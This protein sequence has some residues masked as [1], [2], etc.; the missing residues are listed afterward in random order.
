MQWRQRRRGEE[1]SERRWRRRRGASSS[2]DHRSEGRRLGGVLGLGAAA[3]GGSGAE[4]ER[5]RTGRVGRGSACRRREAPPPKSG[6]GGKHG[7]VQR[8]GGCR[9]A[10]E[11]PQGAGGP[12]LAQ[13]QSRRLQRTPVQSGPSERVLAGHRRARGPL[14]V[15]APSGAEQGRHRQARKVCLAQGPPRARLDCARRGQQ[16]ADGSRSG[17]SMPPGALVPAKVC[18]PDCASLAPGQVGARKEWARG[19]M[20]LLLLQPGRGSP[21][22]RSSHPTEAA[23]HRVGRR[24]RVDSAFP[25]GKGAR[26]LRKGVGKSCA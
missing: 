21:S 23:P 17:P 8:P 10:L 22:C 16:R 4:G 24:G 11:A 25:P 14:W 9:A 6:G 15:R 20:R 5:R 13:P 3:L 2:C 18:W 1:L 19:D 12:A 26:E 7:S